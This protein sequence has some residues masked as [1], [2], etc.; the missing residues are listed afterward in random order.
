MRLGIN[1]VRLTRPFTGVGRYLDRLLAEWA[2]LPLPFDEVVLYTPS[3]L[4]AGRVHFPLDRFPT[5]VIPGRGPDPLW[6]WRALRPRHREVDLLFCP[7]YT[8]PIGYAGPAVVTYFGPSTN[9]RWSLEALRARTYDRMYRYSARRAVRVLT[10]ATWVRDQVV[11]GYGVDATRVDVIPL[12]P[13]P[14]FTPAAAP[15][16]ADRIGRTYLGGARPYVLFVGKLSGRHAI[17]DL[18]AAFAEARARSGCAHALVMVGPNVLGL[19]VPRLGRGAGLPADA[20]VHVPHV[21]EPD[22]PAVYRGADLFVFPASDAE[23]FGL[24]IVE[25]MACGT[26]VLSTARGSVPEVAGEAACLVTGT[27]VRE[28][29]DG[30]AGLLADP[31]RRRALRALGLARAAQFSWRRTAERTM[32]SLWRAA[33]AGATMGGTWT[34]R[35]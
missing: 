30:L 9:R 27:S 17:P 8:V 20:L 31:G 24:P 6:E 32:D 10:G 16:E 4:E 3:P 19:D 1:V 11:R 5:E 22:L 13:A 29:A 23:G 14:G 15:G 12:A 35:A 18:V 26:P 33:T 2:A 34:R 21:P 28:L 7:S 25:A